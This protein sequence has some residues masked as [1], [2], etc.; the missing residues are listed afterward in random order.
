VA[1]LR[2]GVTV[3]LSRMQNVI[4]V[5]P[6]DTPVIQDDLILSS[7]QCLRSSSPRFA[8]FPDSFQQSCK[9]SVSTFAGQVVRYL[10]GLIVRRR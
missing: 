6:P 4:E 7:S 3:N 5:R 1:A 2:G 9:P 10:R 8:A